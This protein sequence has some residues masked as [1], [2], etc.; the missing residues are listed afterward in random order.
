MFST[1]V[2]SQGYPSSNLVCA[3]STDVT[4]CT[5]DQWEP[6]SDGG[7][8]GTARLRYIVGGGGMCGPGTDH[9]TCQDNTVRLVPS[10]CLVALFSHILHNQTLTTVL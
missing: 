6:V 10:P 2:V 8:L 3:S 5:V 4:W 9:Q 1:E 7:W